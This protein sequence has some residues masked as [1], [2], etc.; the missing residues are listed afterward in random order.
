[1][2][3]ENLDKGFVCKCCGSFVKQY[4]RSFNSNM[5]LCLMLL[6]RYNMNG[7]VKVE[8]FLIKNGHKR[9]GDFSYLVH[10]RFLEKQGG[11]RDDGSKRNGYY[12]LT[13][14]GTFFVEGKVKAKKKFIILNNKLQ[15]F[16]GDEIS[17]KEALGKRFSFD[18]LMG[19]FNPKTDKETKTL[20]QLNLL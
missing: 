9:C 13:S 4:T 20:H 11:K 12:R 10:Y 17:I 2:N 16:S 6:Y 1:M 8:D 19:N 18:E 3:E 14:L 7:F 5:A 15:G